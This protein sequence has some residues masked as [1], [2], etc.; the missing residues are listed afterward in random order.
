MKVNQKLKR[1][2][3]LFAPYIAASL[4]I[5]AL[6][7]FGSYQKS[8]DS[9]SPLM[10]SVGES[11][12]LVT[13][14]QLSESFIVADLANSVSLPSADAINEN[15]VTIALKYEISQNSDAK[16]EKPIVID[17]SHLSRG[18]QEY[19]VKDGDT[20]DSIA[21]HFG[22]TPTQIRWSNNLKTSTLS[23]DQKLLL[24]SAPGILYTVKS[25]DTV[26]GLAEKYKSNAEQ[27]IIYNDLEDTGL[28]VG[29]TIILPSGELPE[30]ERPEYVPPA[31]K[32]SYSSSISSANSSMRQNVREVESRAYW[33][34]VYNSVRG[35]GNTAYYGNCTWFAWYWR[36]YNMPANYHLPSRPL[37]NARDWVRTLSGEFY[38]DHNPQYGDVVQTSTSGAYG[39]VAIVEAVHADGSITII[40]MNS[41]GL[42]RVDRAEV[43]ASV[44][45]TYNYI[46]QHK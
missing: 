39:H 24:P 25:G 9:N 35:D 44:A 12:F 26:E 10:N 31:P 6:L 37:G 11:N 46:H 33:T 4:I 17:T 2:I 16:I 32:P 36:R 18:V 19:V 14:D 27:I 8:S 41:I 21:E 40:E 28:Q 45:R 30:I 1:R 13:A 29:S 3:G 5:V 20:L 15:Y 22:L 7:I 43:P 38:V 23:V 42:G 34:N